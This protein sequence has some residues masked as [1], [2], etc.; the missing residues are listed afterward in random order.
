V[1]ALLGRVNAVQDSFATLNRFKEELSK[2]QA[3]LDPLRAPQGGINAR[4]DD[5]HHSSSP[6]SSTS[7]KRQ[8]TPRSARGWRRLPGTRSRSS[9][10]SRGSMIA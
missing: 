7:S 6:R 10:A 3:E 5:L 2:S 8:A 9:S 4:M 1:S